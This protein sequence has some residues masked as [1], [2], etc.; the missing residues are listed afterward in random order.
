MHATHGTMKCGGMPV[1]LYPC[2]CTAIRPPEPD[3]AVSYKS[4]RCLGCPYPRHGLSCF[5][6]LE[7]CLRTDMKEIERRNQVRNSINSPA[8]NPAGGW[9]G[10]AGELVP[11]ARFAV[12]DSE[13][14]TSAEMTRTKGAVAI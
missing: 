2:G 13:P 8:S 4:S 10:P 12:S 6:D 3:K 7:T 14:V 1:P 11:P 5:T 9:R